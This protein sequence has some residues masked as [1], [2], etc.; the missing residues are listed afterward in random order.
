M[1][2]GRN[3]SNKSFARRAAD[4]CTALPEEFLSPKTKIFV[5]CSTLQFISTG[6]VS[7]I[8][9]ENHQSETIIQLCLK[10]QP[11]IYSNRIEANTLP[12]S[13]VTRRYQNP[14]PSPN[15]SPALLPKL[16]KALVSATIPLTANSLTKKSFYKHKLNLK[17]F[18]PRY[19]RHLKTDLKKQNT[20]Y[21][22]PTSKSKS[23]EKSLPKISFR[24]QSFLTRLLLLRC[25]D[26]ER[27]P[28]M[29][30]T[31]GE[32]RSASRTRNDRSTPSLRVTSYNVR[33]LS[34]EKKLRHLIN[35]FY[36][37]RLSKEVDFIACL[38]E[39]YIKTEGKIPYLWRGNYHLTPGGGHS[40]GCLTLLSAHINIIASR[41]IEDRAHVLACQRSDDLKVTYIIANIYAPNPNSNEK[42]EFFE[43]VLSTVAEFEENFDCAN[44][45]VLGD[46]NL[47][48]KGTE[49]KNRQHSIQEKRVASTVS[50]TYKTMGLKDIWDSEQKFTWRRPGTDI[51]ST[52][53]RVLYKADFIEPIEIE[54][55]WALSNSDHAAIE[56]KFKNV[57]SHSRPRSNRT[58][59]DPSVLDDVTS[60][61][62]FE[63]ELMDRLREIPGNWD[64]HMR[65]EFTKVCIRS[66]LERLQAE[67]K[68]KEKTEEEGI[69]EELEV[70]IDALANGRTRNKDNLI[71]YVEELRAKK[72]TLVE[73]KGKR[74]ADKLGTKWYNEGEKSTRY[75]M[76]ILNRNMPDNFK[77]IKGGN[78]D[79]I[80]DPQKVE[81]EI[82]KFYRT[83]Y[84]TQHVVLE[85]DDSFFND[86]QSIPGQ[87]SSDIIRPI[88]VEELRAT[89][90]SCVDSAPG[91]DG[92]S[93]SILGAIWPTFAPILCEA[94]NHS[95]R[96][97]NLPP[98]HKQSLLKLIP[99][100]G[101]DL[102][103]LANWRPITLSNCDHKLITKI[104]AKRMGEAV[105]SVIKERQTA[106]LK[107]RLIN[108]NIRSI[109]ATIANV[110]AE[111]T[112][113]LLLSLDAKKAFDSVSHEYIEKCLKKFGCEGFVP[114][115]KILY[116]D[117]RTD[118]LINGRTVNG[119]RILK[120]VKQG[121]SLSCILFIMC[122]EPLLANIES[123]NLIEA[124]TSHSLSCS[125]PK[126]YAY[127]D[128][129]NATIKDTDEGIKELFREY[130]RLSKISGLELNADKTEILQFGSSRKR[131][132]E[133]PYL[134]QIHRLESSEQVKI[135]GIYFQ[136]EYSKTVAINVRNIKEKIDA[137]LRRW[138]R[139]NLSILAKI[140]IVK[141][142]G[143]SQVI[144]AMQSLRFDKVHYKEIN[145]LLY[146]FIWNRHY[147]AA[148]APERIK[149]NI[150]N[151]PIKLGGFGMLDVEELDN[152][153]KLKALGRLLISKHPFIKILK[154]EVNLVN[155]FEPRIGT[156]I[157]PVS[158]KAIE[159]LEQDRSKLWQNEK[160]STNK[161]FI[162]TIREQKLT[163]IVSRRGQLGLAYFI[164]R[165]RGA[166]LVKDLTRADLEDLRHH[167]DENKIKLLRLAVSLRTPTPALDFSRSYI[168][169][170]RPKL[171][172]LCSS[173]EI[174][175]H[176][177][178]LTP[179]TGLKIGI[180]L[181][182]Q[183]SVNWGLKVSKLTSTQHKSL[184]LR[185]AH[186]DIYTKDKLN[187]FGLID[188]NKCPRCDEVETL[189]HKFV[190][191]IYTQRIWQALSRHHTRIL[192]DYPSSNHDIS[193]ALGTFNNS[194]LT[195][196]TLVAEI[197]QIISRLKDEP[198]YLILPKKVISIAIKTLIVKERNS[199]IKDLLLTLRTD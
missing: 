46:F 147:L 15:P 169:T 38:Q 117:L 110:N 33:G 64:P 135:N 186:G 60:K 115:F 8:E 171:M 122:I 183:E 170:D 31:N 19:P 182:I 34:D 20:H 85:D 144:F 44:L 190:T 173:K 181:T 134:G 191:C 54:T 39:T 78:G 5:R 94:W 164:I 52:I 188:S 98:S 148:K 86:I 37:K 66:I 131:A 118:I 156:S 17:N 100:A 163:S 6:T 21:P 108:D 84:E 189:H 24:H 146:K 82:V 42:I 121:D 88:T 133:A 128:D 101:K 140:L 89:L 3:V 105:A 153:L 179:V 154:A 111:N 192:G 112:P 198:T 187:R 32:A 67:R 75:F 155:Y 9:C 16:L 106:Y 18:I 178:N 40:C 99:K 13:G 11:K 114:I 129:V 55:F 65:L 130:E 76:R 124:I 113:G 74:L 92:I 195:Y 176:R 43:N 48:F 71:E 197:L 157:D 62:T 30:P 180:N 109:L 137:Q 196:L 81:E 150:V 132:F 102:N 35:S 93:Y 56:V 172:D 36:A 63:A 184:I 158:M 70:A 166:R 59:L 83:L 12:C 119:F 4:V 123:N 69:S 193:L 136:K 2:K 103:N 177:V 22:D 126:A 77:S 14:S 104:Y 143:I 23:Q 47:I 151:T 161:N 138:S 145:Y 7:D 142:F 51:F 149:R 72:S 10:I 41:N 174:R 1:I 127:A 79:L 160:L 194:N 96:T 91:P 95:L 107:G 25:Y 50:D 139:R 87:S 26:V 61:T 68:R 159:L 80:T 141:T 53:D 27:N 120:G 168:L 90:H 167:V 97:G 45:I 57:R 73:E 199:I 165:G 162:S 152:S 29:E 49:Q 185:V 116:K 175:N 58:R 28:G 125:L